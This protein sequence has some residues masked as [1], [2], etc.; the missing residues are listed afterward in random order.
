[1]KVKCL[2][3]CLALLC[4]MSLTAWA[5]TITW[6]GGGELENWSDM[7]NWD[8]GIPGSA[9]TALFGEAGVGTTTVLDPQNLPGAPDEWTI[10]GLTASNTT[11]DHGIDLG[12]KLLSIDGNLSVGVQALAKTL[13]ISNGSLVIGSESARRSIYLGVNDRWNPPQSSGTLV[14]SSVN[15]EAWLNDC[16][17]GQGGEHRADAV[18]DLQNAVIPSGV[19]RANRLQVG[20]APNGRTT[21]YLKLSSSTGLTDVFVTNELRIGSDNGLGRIGDPNDNY[22]L[23]ANVSFTLG[24]Q[25]VTRCAMYV[26]GPSHWGGPSD[27]LLEASAGGAFNAYLGTLIV[28]E[29]S[30]G[31][32]ESALGILDLSAMDSIQMDVQNIRIAASNPAGDPNRN[33]MKGY[34][35]LP[36]GAVNAGTLIVCNAGI[37]PESAKAEAVLELNG[38]VCAVATSATVGPKGTLTTTLSGL[39]AGLDLADGAMLTATG[40]VH[41]VFAQPPSNPEGI[42]WGLR[43]SGNHLAQLLSLKNDG[44]LT[45]D[46]SAIEGTVDV[47]YDVATDATYVAVVQAQANKPPIARVK[48]ISVAYDPA[49]GETSVTVDVTDVDDGSFDPDG[50]EDVA[51]IRI[52]CTNDIEDP[53]DPHT[54]TL[55]TPDAFIVTLTIEDVAGLTGSAECTVTVFNPEPTQSNL[56]WSGLA[57][58]EHLQ[59]NWGLNWVG[60]NPPANPTAGTL[61]FA[62]LAAVIDGSVTSTLDEDRTIGGL[63]GANAAGDHNID[64]TSQR[65]TVLGNL[66]VGQQ[67]LA[68][69]L[70]V[71]NGT[72]QIGSAAQKQNIFLGID[73]RWSPPQSS[74]TL[75]LSGVSLEAWLNDCVVGQGGEHRADGILDLTGATIAGGTFKANRLRVGYGQNG[76]TYGYMKVGPATGL[77]ELA[78]VGELLIGS[79]NGVARIGDPADNYRL[80]ANVNLTWGVQGTTRCNVSI[81]GRSH[82]MYIPSDGKLVASSGGTCSAYLGTLLVGDHENG[83]D[84]G[85]LGILDL[86]AMDSINMDVQNVRIAASNPAGDPAANQMKGYVYLPP[87]TVNAGS[88][89][90]CNAGVQPTSAGV[91]AVLELNGTTFSVATALTVGCKGRVTANLAGTSSGLDLASAATLT[92]ADGGVINVVFAEPADTGTYW[93]LR[94]AGDHSGEL[95]DLADTGK[96]T[97]DDTALPA[98]AAIFTDAEYTYVGAALNLAKVT[99][100]GVTDATSGS[101]LVTNAAGVV[102]AIVGEPAEGQTIDGYAVNETGAEPAAG[103]WQASVTSCTIQAASGSTVTLYG[104]VKDT[105]GNTA[106]KTASIYFNTAAP[107]A[108]AVVVVDNGDG[109]ATATWTTDILAEGSLNYGPVSLSGATPNVVAEAELGTSH[110]A[111]FSFAAGTNYKLVAVNTEVASD[112]IYWPLAWPIEGDSN[113]D[114][115]VNIL[116]LIFIRNKLNLDVASGDNWKADVNKDTRINILDL[117]FVRN[118][119]NTQCP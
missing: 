106:S 27:G 23:P 25:D 88:A 7:N 64:L 71:S 105:A 26:G 4:L 35:Y 11:G 12:S 6:T 103:E 108:S 14:L 119:L 47:I 100:F 99:S 20:Y 101:A 36:P 39:P 38:T 90:V 48:D 18:L 74:G 22:R 50:P 49:M 37:Q 75:V 68:R 80:P 46:S 56:T 59:W 116:D 51:D 118:K 102:I 117:I 44:H 24:V 82:W 93:G 63:I 114:C 2:A 89:I 29:H 21:G 5:A 115:R 33:E 43:W 111:T 113:M 70:T 81:G 110:S 78:V 95:Q 66:T 94:W 58:S 30:N 10:G 92:V 62:D 84:G 69:T 87:G 73:D 34:V 52:F 45:W 86:A 96:L 54:V 61:T 41:V 72:L 19:F 1:M 65:L 57:G 31:T 98:P 67:V 107:V 77:N 53:D 112:P 40:I 79:D 13:A 28:G 15:L 76:I 16:V 32:D 85:A 97:W 17:V 8:S 91:Q 42:Y 55:N 60:S 104:W 83:T 109:T 9:D 3:V